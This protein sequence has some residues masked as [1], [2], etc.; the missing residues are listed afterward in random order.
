MAETVMVMS[1]TIMTAPDDLIAY[2]GGAHI[3][4]ERGLHLPPRNVENHRFLYVES[5]NGEFIIPDGRLQLD[6][7][8]LLLLSPG[9]REI[10]YDDRRPVSYTYIEFS[11]T[12][13][14][15]T[16]P[17]LPVPESSPHFRTL[18]GLL[19]S[20]LHEDGDGTESVIRAAIDLTLRHTSPDAAGPT[21]DDRIRKALDYISRNLNRPLKVSELADL[22]GLS[23]PQF[24]RVFRANMSIGPKEHLLR[25]RM[26]YARRIL[27]SEGLQVSDVAELLQ[28]ETL[29]QFSKQYKK[30]HGH[31][32]TRRP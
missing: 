29:Y 22:A 25:T 1:K 15:I 13:N 18:I 31:S 32:P 17:W 30:V 28:F 11:V 24:R 14:L 26:H 7:R 19:R 9:V 20:T 10:R 12:R 5:G 23:E 21:V 27:E 16:K 4:F 2:V 6:D 8:V 3:R